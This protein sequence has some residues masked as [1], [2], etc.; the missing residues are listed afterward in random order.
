[1][2]NLEARKH[3]PINNGGKDTSVRVTTNDDQI[4][5]VDH[6]GSYKSEGGQQ[7]RKKAP[8]RQIIL[9]HFLEFMHLTIEDIDAFIAKKGR[10][11]Y[12]IND[13]E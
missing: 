8:S 10:C 12:N 4:H 2:L 6:I 11:A 1:M 3:F 5:P 7:S 9:I 13:Q